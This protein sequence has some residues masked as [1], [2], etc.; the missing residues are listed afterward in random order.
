MIHKIVEYAQLL[1]AWWSIE[2]GCC[3]ES[4]SLTNPEAGKHV[5]MLESLAM[6]GHPGAV[7]PRRDVDHYCVMLNGERQRSS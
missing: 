4:F 1:K 7:I 5:F 6:Y 2:D 3:K